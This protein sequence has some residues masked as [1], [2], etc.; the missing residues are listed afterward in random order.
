[1]KE[2]T[3]V[4][5]VLI[6]IILNIIAGGFFIFLF[7][8]IDAPDIY[9]KIEITDLTSEEIQLGTLIDISNA[10]PFDLT[11]KNIKIV[12]ET[13]DG[14]EFTSYSFKG[15][16]VPSNGKKSFESKDSIRLQGDIPKVLVNTI[17]ADVGV[18]FLGFI[19]KI[20]PI[21]V[22]IILSVEDFINNIS[23]PKIQIH[24]GIRDIT[25]DGL[26]FAADIEISN[27]SNIE[28]NVND[29]FVDLK[30]EEGNSVGSISIDGGI[31]EPKETLNL[32][33]SGIIEYEALNSKSIIIDVNGQI[34]INAAGLNQSLT[35]ATSA[36]I[37]IPNLSDLLK[38]NNDTFDFSLFGEFKIRLRGI[39]TVVDLKVFNPSNIP[40]E[41]QDIKCIIYGITGDNKKVI[42][43]K[44]ME[45][46]NVSSKNEVCISTQIRIPYLK[47]IFSG[48][49]RIL[50]EWFGIRLEGNFAINGTNQVI[51]ISING[52]IDPY[53]FR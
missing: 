53:F 48:T 33:V 39:T 21:K 44:D 9:A 29:I 49:G 16:T 23:I 46:C 36:V 51:P 11:L 43:E 28:F 14:D 7:F 22:V 34:T 10:N 17:T 12:S 1:M 19:E 5:L 32:D 42:A 31:L 2:K 26:I 13:K 18:K 27:P 24:G 40:L 15:G 47:L 25:E 3:K 45:S 37:E 35:L 8:T 4:I 20:I 52:F 30:T 6:L 50:P 41:I 38:L